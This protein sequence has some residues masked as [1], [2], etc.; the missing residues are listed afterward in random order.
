MCG[1]SARSDH[2]IPRSVQTVDR[3]LF[4]IEMPVPVSRYIRARSLS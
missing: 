1:D 4:V 3:N 2:C